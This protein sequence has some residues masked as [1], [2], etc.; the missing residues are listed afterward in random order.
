[1]DEDAG[2]GVPRREEAAPR[3]LGPAW[4]R[5]VQVHVAGAQAEPVHRR[6]VA[7]R[8]ALV[9]VQH[10]LGFG[11]RARGEVEQQRV[12][13]LRRPIGHEL[14]RRVRAVGVALPTRDRAADGDARVVAG[15]RR[16][17]VGLRAGR[18]H[19]P[20]RAALHAVAQVLGGQQRGGRDQHRAELDRREHR[21]PQRQLVAEHHQQAV[22]APH[23]EA[24]QVVGDLRRALR[25][26]AERALQL[27]AVV[28]DDPQ[29]GGL[30]VARDRVEVIERPVEL[31]QHGPAELA[32]RGGLVGAQ[33]QQQV[34]RGVEGLERGHGRRCSWKWALARQGCEGRR[35]RQHTA[36]HC[37]VDERAAVRHRFGL[38]SRAD[39]PAVVLESASLDV[40]K[41]R[42]VH[43]PCSG[44][45]CVLRWRRRRTRRT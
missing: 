3:V 15:Q 32:D 1:M 7:D 28:A 11:G 12:A 30:V 26:L 41:P 27:A 2:A 22:A 18:D 13:R 8:V 39:A 37:R 19:V 4:R 44:V 38:N 6:Q 42:L 40:R 14:G 5:D 21:L 17:L 29:R 33:A 36:V 45:H 35:C 31:A 24:A 9:G 34:A 20:H 25:Q 16:E 10:Q 23:A 43:C